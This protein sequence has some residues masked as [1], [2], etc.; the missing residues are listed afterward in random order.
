M[1]IVYHP[2]Q[3]LNATDVS[4]VS[5][6]VLPE[7]IRAPFLASRQLSKA[8]RVPG[9]KPAD[10]SAGH[11][12]FNRLEDSRD[13]VRV[14]PWPDQKME[15]LGHDNVRPYVKGMFLPGLGDSVD[16]IAAYPLIGQQRLSAIAGER[17]RVGVARVVVT[18]AQ[19][20][21]ATLCL[22]SDNVNHHAL[23]CKRSGG[24]LKQSETQSS[25]ACGC[26]W[27]RRVPPK[28]THKLRG[29]RC[30]GA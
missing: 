23:G 14:S 7:A 5:S 8:T 26:L 29:P 17:Q 11:G 28:H 15:V 12:L 27:G 1:H 10:G 19:L 9:S 3:G 22:H 20:P 16:Y 21:M 18:S 24:T 4:I 6:P 2:P 13:G 25:A 30:R